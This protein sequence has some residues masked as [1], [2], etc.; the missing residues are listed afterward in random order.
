MEFAAALTPTSHAAHALPMAMTETTEENAPNRAPNRIPL[1]QGLGGLV[2]PASVI[3]ALPSSESRAHARGTARLTQAEPP[4]TVMWSASCHGSGRA[5]CH[6]VGSGHQV[7]C[8][9][10][11]VPG[12]DGSQQLRVP[13]RSAWPPSLLSSDQ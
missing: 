6:A 12:P 3:A 5:A 9:W 10:L 11:S 7:G 1:D 13:L 4:C 2:G 8:R